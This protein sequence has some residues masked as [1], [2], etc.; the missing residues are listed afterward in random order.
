MPEPFSTYKFKGKVQSVNLRK[1]LHTL[2]NEK[3][4]PGL[5]F[6]HGHT[7]EVTALLPSDVAVRDS[8]LAELRTRLA[9]RPNKPS[10]IENEHYTMEPSDERHQLKPVTLGS[11]AVKK[12]VSQPAFDRL[13]KT[14]YEYQQRWLQDRYRLA[15]KNNKLVGRLP[16]EA[17]A[18]VRG[19]APVYKQSS[20][21]SAGLGIG[22]SLL[23]GVRSIGRVAAHGVANTMKPFKAMPTLAATQPAGAF[24]AVRNQ[25]AT[26]GNELIGKLQKTPGFG[27]YG[28]RVKGPESMMAHGTGVTNDLLGLRMRSSGG[29]GPQQME[30]LTKH[31]TDAGM[32]LQGAPKQLVRPGYHGWNVKGT[33]N[34][35]PTE[36]QVTPRRLQGLSAVDHDAVYK[37]HVLGVSPTMSKVIQPAV[38]FGMNMI[39]PMSGNGYRYARYG[40]GIAGAVGAGGAATALAQ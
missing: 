39:S 31:L 34:G 33:Y 35:V 14:P 27:M 22:R 38:Q 8:I 15:L 36:I 9:N 4:H 28:A 13:A 5:A 19:E 2:L 29:Y 21:L 40:A 26:H 24:A 12:F 25:A 32:T 37:P 18:Q 20:P 16:A 3:G 1:T 10:L 30:Q 17:I 7:G 11:R 6:N 23:G